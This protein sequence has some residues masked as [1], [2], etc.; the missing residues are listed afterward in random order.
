MKIYLYTGD[1][2]GKTTNGLGIALRAIGHGNHVLM[3]QF[4]KWKKEIGEYRVQFQSP[5][6]HD[7]FLVRQ[8]GRNGW[9]GFDNLTTE[10]A[11]LAKEGLLFA[12]NAINDENSHFELLILDEINLAVHLKLITIKEVELFLAHMPENINIVMTGRS[13]PQ[14]LMDMADVVNEIRELK[15]PKEFIN[16][17]GVQY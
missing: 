6:I 4:L 10:D 7:H 3:V 15:A 9:I 14:E 1:G 12:H 13:A 8:F 16:E 2:A 11:I 17:K 5:Y